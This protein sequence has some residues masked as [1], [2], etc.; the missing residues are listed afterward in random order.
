MP[1]GEGAVGRGQGSL[2]PHRQL[3]VLWS[4]RPQ[5][6]LPPLNALS[7][8]LGGGDVLL[9]VGGDPIPSR[10]GWGRKVAVG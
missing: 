6:C 1:V 7:S 10:S 3:A 2:L 8:S 9:A 4:S 5:I